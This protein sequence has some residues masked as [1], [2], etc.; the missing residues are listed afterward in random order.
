MS[1]WK[2][3]KNRKSRR[4][5]ILRRILDGLSHAQYWLRCH[6]YN[7]YHV[8]NLSGEDSYNWGWLDTD[9]KMLLAC[10]KLLREFVEQENSEVGLLTMD[11]YC[12]HGS[13]ESCSSQHEFVVNQL[14]RDH[15]VRELYRWWTVTRPANHAASDGSDTIELGEED[16]RML[17][18]LISLRGSLWT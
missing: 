10:F 9:H 4:R 5:S 12:S 18:R 13:P 7:R 15:R 2:D 3:I 14:R 6:T 16:D 17:H 11:D 8:L 1:L